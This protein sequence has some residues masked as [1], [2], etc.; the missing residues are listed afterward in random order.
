MALLF[1]HVPLCTSVTK[2]HLV[3]IYQ[4]IFSLSA[5]SDAQYSSKTLGIRRFP[6]LFNAKCCSLQI[7]LIV[8]K[9]RLN[10]CLHINFTV[11]KNTVYSRK[12]WSKKTL[13]KYQFL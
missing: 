7:I 2:L 12:K 9:P 6:K 8:H 4:N 5:V 11:W 3:C 13:V 1:I 10:S